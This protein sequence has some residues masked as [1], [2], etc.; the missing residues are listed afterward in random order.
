MESFRAKLKILDSMDEKL[1]VLDAFNKSLKELETAVKEM[2][3]WLVDG[4][5]RMDDLLKPPQ[6]ILPEERV[7]YTMEL[8]SDTENQIK[9]HTEVF[10]E[11]EKIKPTEKH[12]ESA[13]A[14]VIA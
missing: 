14:E 13:E 3:T 6:P 11:W 10:A 2:E 9:K 8:Q 12:E 4:R 7:M 5:K 1:K